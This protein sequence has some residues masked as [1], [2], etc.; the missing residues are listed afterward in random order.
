MDAL[1]G[2]EFHTI[3]TAPGV[4][5]RVLLARA[6]GALADRARGTVLVSPGRTEFIEKYAEVVGD[7][8][9]RGF[10]V[11][12]VDHRGQGRSTRPLP[13][14]P[15]GHIGR[16]DDYV[17]DLDAVARWLVDERGAAQPLLVLAHSM[18]GAIAMLW[19]AR[20]PAHVAGAVMSAPMFGLH[21]K[22]APPAV[23]AAASLMVRL[24]LGARV[25]PSAARK[26]AREPF[27]GNVLTHSPERH[28]AWQRWLDRDPSLGVAG[29]T[30]GWL[31]Q[32]FSAA[33]R[34]S[35]PKLLQRIET[36]VVVVSAA[37]EALV[38]NRAHTRA[39][40]LLPRITHHT[41]EGA[42]H[43]LLLET[44]EVRAQFWRFF[45]ELA[46]R[47]APLEASAAT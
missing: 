46:N 12:V 28:D 36:P 1:A 3:D 23:G 14:V 39:A 47:L 26:V 5:I 44:D 31:E 19:L 16:F 7:L 6:A 32:A 24:G 20:R 18:G 15:Y 33:K 37:E 38:D 17:D 8:T 41:I 21:P 43:E 25:L 22:L 27:E 35:D 29:A 40:A 13:K 42:R 2:G 30:W 9:A 34:L 11:C 4:R 10:D 45:D